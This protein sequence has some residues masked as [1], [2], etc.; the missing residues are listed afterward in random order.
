MA[1]QIYSMTVADITLHLV[2]KS[3]KYLRIKVRPPEGRVHLSVPLGM[4][5]DAVR[6]AVLSKMDWIRKQRIRFATQPK[7]AVL[8][9]VSGEKIPFQGRDYEL[10]VVEQNGRPHVEL[11]EDGRIGLYVKPG[12]DAGTRSNVL[13]VW[14]RRELKTA[15][16]PLMNKWQRIMGVE[17][18]EWRI[19]QMKTR[20]GTC[21]TRVKRIWLNLELIKQPEHL[22]EF[23]IVHELTHLL[24]PS[25]NGRFKSMMDGYM[26]DWRERQKE[27]K[28]SAL[29]AAWMVDSG[30]LR[31]EGNR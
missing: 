6:H 9:Y 3:V 17:V 25:H 31:E 15:V 28:Q 4:S 18:S 27:L 10:N 23:I 1:N 7:R 13:N 21:N 24:E 30:R 14:Y 8:E 5:D 11:R 29:R 19:K 26:P 2:R 22:L 16:P 12:S 20:W